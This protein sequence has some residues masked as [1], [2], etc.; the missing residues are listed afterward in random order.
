LLALLALCQDDEGDLPSLIETG[1]AHP[2]SQ[3]A[4]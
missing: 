1:M 4:G 2:P 3:P